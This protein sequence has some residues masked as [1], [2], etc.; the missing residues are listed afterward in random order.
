M[1]VL[2]VMR[3][4]PLML[5]VA[6]SMLTPSSL[7]ISREKL[8]FFAGH[9]GNEQPLG[10]G[11]SGGCLRRTE[12][13]LVVLAQGK[14]G[15]VVAASGQQQDDACYGDGDGFH[16]ESSSIWHCLKIPSASIG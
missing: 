15:G 9:V 11:P 1:P 6:G 3:L 10:A 7:S 16:G 14:H 13:D 8:L 12:P 4:T 2:R 5:P